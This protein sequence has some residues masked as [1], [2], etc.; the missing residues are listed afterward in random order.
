ML[1][2]EQFLKDLDEDSKKKGMRFSDTYTFRGK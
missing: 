2:K 1:V